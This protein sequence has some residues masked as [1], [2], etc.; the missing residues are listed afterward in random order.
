MVK[1]WF[2]STAK[3]TVT[4]LYANTSITLDS[5]TSRST[6]PVD[7]TSS[8]SPAVSLQH[9]ILSIY[10]IVN[11]LEMHTP[12]SCLLISDQYDQVVESI[13]WNHH[14]QSSSKFR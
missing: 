13:D 8:T 6:E 7:R 1:L 2:A 3:S 12:D 14:H 5:V 11:A 10:Y 4:W 9:K